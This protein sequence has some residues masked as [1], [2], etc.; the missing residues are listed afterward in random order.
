MKFTAAL[1][2]RQ[3]GRARHQEIPWKSAE[4]LCQGLRVDSARLGRTRARIFQAPNFSRMLYETCTFCAALGCGS[5]SA[6]P[7]RWHMC[8]MA[9]GRGPTRARQRVL[10]RARHPERQNSLHAHRLAKPSGLPPK[11]GAFNRARHA[12]K[13]AR[14]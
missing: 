14:G 6:S 4:G 11:R 5:A 9:K 7:M 2:A 13:G 12:T 3:H 1:L 8:E 10:G